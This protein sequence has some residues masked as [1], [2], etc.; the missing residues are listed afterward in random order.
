MPLPS[1]RKIPKVDPPQERTTAPVAAAPEALPAA[2]RAQAPAPCEVTPA[3]SR[4]VVR[5]EDLPGVL[6]SIE[7]K[8]FLATKPTNERAYA[9]AEGLAMGL[10]DGHIE[11]DRGAKA[12]FAVI[13][14]VRVPWAEPRLTALYQ[15]AGAN[16]YYEDKGGRAFPCAT[17]KIPSLAGSYVQAALAAPVTEVSAA[18]IQKVTERLQWATTYENKGTEF[19]HSMARKALNAIRIQVEASPYAGKVQVPAPGVIPPPVVGEKMNAERLAAHLV[20]TFQNANHDE[21]VA[22]LRKIPMVGKLGGGSYTTGNMLM[23]YMQGRMLGFEVSILGGKTSFATVNRQPKA[24][25]VPLAIVGFRKLPARTAGGAAASNVAEGLMADPDEE[26]ES[27]DKASKG[28]KTFIQFPTMHVL[29]ISQTEQIPG[30]PVIDIHGDKLVAALI[31]GKLDPKVLNAA[32]E[33]MQHDGIQ[34]KLVPL[35]QFHFGSSAGGEVRI[36]EGMTTE[37]MFATLVH[38]WGHER[39]HQRSIA[40]VLGNEPPVVGY[41]RKDDPKPLYGAGRRREALTMV[42]A[43]FEADMTAFFVGRACGIDTAKA[44]AMHLKGCGMTDRQIGDG[45][46]GGALHDYQMAESFKLT[47][48]EADQILKA[49]KD[50]LPK[51]EGAGPD[52]GQGARG[53][54]AKDSSS[55]P[56]GGDVLKDA[57]PI[58]RLLDAPEGFHGLPDGQ[59]RVNVEMGKDENGK[60]SFGYAKAEITKVHQKEGA[61]GYLYDVEYDQPESLDGKGYARVPADK[62]IFGIQDPPETALDAQRLAANYTA[63]PKAVYLDTETTGLGEFDQWVSLAMVDASGN[64]LLNLRN[65]PTVAM[66][67]FAVKVNGMTDEVVQQFPS[68]MESHWVLTK[69]LKDLETLG[70]NVGFDK[71]IIEQTALAHNVPSP[72]RGV[73][74]WIDL[75]EVEK[76]LSGKARFSNLMN[77]CLD[78]GVNLTNAHDALGDITGTLKLAQAMAVADLTPEDAFQGGLKRGRALELTP[79]LILNT[80]IVAAASKLRVVNEVLGLRAKDMAI[81]SSY[82]PTSAYDVAMF[83]LLHRHLNKVSAAFT[84]GKAVSLHEVGS[85]LLASAKR[86]L[87]YGPGVLGIPEVEGPMKSLDVASRRVDLSLRIDHYRVAVARWSDAKHEVAV[88]KGEMDALLE[89]AAKFGADRAE[90]AALRP[91]MKAEQDRIEAML[92]SGDARFNAAVAS[93]KDATMAAWLAGVEPISATHA[94]DGQFDWNGAALDSEFLFDGTTLIAKDSMTPSE[95]ERLAKKGDNHNTSEARLKREFSEIQEAKTFVSMAPLGVTPASGQG[96]MALPAV[97]WL[98]ERVIG[99]DYG[100]GP[101]VPLLA[102]T[103]SLMRRTGFDGVVMVEAED[104]P[105]LGFWQQGKF[106]GITSPAVLRDANRRPLTPLGLLPDEARVRAILNDKGQAETSVA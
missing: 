4:E 67:P 59:C 54:E 24:D 93:L 29:D 5:V 23:A 14:E 95:A 43:E 89:L 56:P 76:V 101:L 30:K 40:E 8:T 100:H 58:L 96:R 61:P 78:H 21:F 71:R 82:S 48:K 85:A 20:T 99:R 35:A 45:L 51:P 32:M 81:P 92:A 22:E 75:M 28:P 87:G 49:I 55:E 94:S 66:D 72:T 17:A 53:K 88:S 50:H 39:L 102:D 90:V 80:G 25:A 104:G 77:A 105:R 84:E 44:A 34:V 16:G 74:D 2:P 6:A 46:M 12:L 33:A 70:F 3:F 31:D 68:Y 27:Q 47:M 91:L 26:P 97:V 52:Q 57:M 42:Q 9:V 10:K 98:Q 7:D 62:L 79:D 60:R 83:A 73:K 15:T 65:R 36:L 64:V 106:V 37:K 103:W 86:T 18:R 19:D 1:P 63:N 69:A 38:E 13:N 11:P 41:E